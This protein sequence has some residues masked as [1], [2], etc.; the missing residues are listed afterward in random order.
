MSGRQGSSSSARAVAVAEAARVFQDR[1]D[2]LLDRLTDRV[3]NAPHPGTTEWLDE[4][5]RPSL[6]P[7]ERQRVRTAILVAAGYLPPL[8]RG[9]APR[10]SMRT[11]PDQLA[12]F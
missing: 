6:S 10:R 9:E 4:F 7:Q 2:V 3:V 11:N 1:V 8:I 5:R 12:I